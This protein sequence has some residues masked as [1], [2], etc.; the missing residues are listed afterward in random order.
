[1]IQ[2]CALSPLLFNTAQE[3]LAIATSQEKEI[4]ISI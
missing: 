2:K 3:F 4:K 1:M